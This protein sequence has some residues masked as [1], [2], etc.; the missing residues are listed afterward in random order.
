MLKY[1]FQNSIYRAAYICLCLAMASKFLGMLSHFPQSLSE[2]MCV[3]E[4][5]FIFPFVIGD[6][7]NSNPSNHSPPNH[8]FHNPRWNSGNKASTKSRNSMLDFLA[9]DL[10]SCEYVQTPFG[11][12]IWKSTISTIAM[13]S[14]NPV[15]ITK[16]LTIIVIL[17][18]IHGYWRLQRGCWNG[19]LCSM[20]SSM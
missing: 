3:K 2:N 17:N 8:N 18:R 12:S 13:H 1:N 9:V 20:G 5:T 15:T 19:H 7:N 11:A 16:L 14:P 6:L 10:P 4:Q